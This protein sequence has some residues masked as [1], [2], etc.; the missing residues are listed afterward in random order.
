MGSRRGRRAVSPSP[1]DAVVNRVWRSVAGTRRAL[2]R[3]GSTAVP[4]SVFVGVPRSDWQ[5]WTNLLADRHEAYRAVTRPVA[6]GVTI[7][8]VSSRPHLLATVVAD[9]A[10][11][12]HRDLEFVLVCNDERYDDID[13]GLALAPLAAAAIRHSSIRRSSSDSLGVCLNAGFEVATER[14]VAKFDDDDR[15]G[16]KYL[17]DALR[18]HSYAGAGVVGKHSYYAHLVEEDQ[19][20]LRFPANEFRY[21]STLAGGSLVFDR[22][23]TDDLRFADISLGEDR[24]FIASCHRRG[25]STF[26][27]DRFN[28]VQTRSVDN[29][30]QIPNAT[31]MQ[32]SRVIADGLDLSVV[33]R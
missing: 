19:T 12:T 33:N 16:P 6:A 5:H 13:L 1:V 7:V 15:Y 4:R 10:A 17:E 28:F 20:V 9:V 23:R 30:W 11:Q 27:A 8:C 26:S 29:T 24:A 18:A 2:T 25:I 22:N 32:N 21:S 3:A 31:Y 14:F